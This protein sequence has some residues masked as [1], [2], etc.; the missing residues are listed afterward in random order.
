MRRRGRKNDVM[1]MSCADETRSCF[2]SNEI[3]LTFNY[4]LFEK[5]IVLGEHPVEEGSMLN[6]ESNDIKLIFF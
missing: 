5:M 2:I 3:D 4:H 6:K 1:F